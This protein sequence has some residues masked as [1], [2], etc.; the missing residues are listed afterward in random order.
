M[1]IL[2]FQC[3]SALKENLEYERYLREVVNALETDDEFRKKLDNA[4]DVDIRV[5]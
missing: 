4:T 2:F 5:S 1:G 3:I